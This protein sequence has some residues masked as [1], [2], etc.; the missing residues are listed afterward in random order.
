MTPHNAGHRLNH[1]FLSSLA[2]DFI[3]VVRPASVALLCPAFLSSL[4]QDFIEVGLLD[5]D[6]LVG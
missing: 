5:A 3:E 1:I 4:A 2:Q 6:T